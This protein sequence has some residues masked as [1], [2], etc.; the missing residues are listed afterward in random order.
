MNH[1]EGKIAFDQVCACIKSFGGWLKDYKDRPLKGLGDPLTTPGL[2]SRPYSKIVG[3]P[4]TTEE[5]ALGLD[6]SQIAT[7][8]TESEQP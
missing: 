5:I 8:M 4:L 1:P 2:L 3:V 7:P 6:G